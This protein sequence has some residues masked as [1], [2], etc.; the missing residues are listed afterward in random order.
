[1]SRLRGEMQVRALPEVIASIDSVLASDAAKTDRPLRL[2]CFVV[3]GDVNLEIDAPAARDDWDAALALATEIGDRKWQSRANGEL[4]MIAFILGD[5]G[6]ALSQ[7]SQAL[8]AATASGDFGAEI[9][10]YAAIATGLNLSGA[11][12]Q[13]LPYFD[14]AL[15]TASKHKETGFQYISVWGKAKALLG[16]G[17]IDEAERL[18]DEGL[19][20]RRQTTA[21]SR[22]FRCL[23]PRRTLPK[24]AD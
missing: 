23:S 12:G 7:V 17:R 15:D 4:G 18:V 9:R 13:A 14:R 3:R 22:R 8:F 19:Q 21:E 24:P 16:L 6:T 1:M 10:Y 20:Q 5:A 2:R 11:Y